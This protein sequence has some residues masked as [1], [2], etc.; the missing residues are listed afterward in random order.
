[1]RRLDAIDRSLAMSASGE[2][3]HEGWSFRRWRDRITAHPAAG[4]VVGG[5]APLTEPGDV[6]VVWRDE[7]SLWIEEWGGWLIFDLDTNSGRSCGV[8]PDWL[9]GQCLLVTAQRSAAR[10]KIA[11]H[12]RSRSL[13]GLY[14]DASIPP[15][16]RPTLPRVFARDQLFYA[17]GLGMNCS[18]SQKVP[19]GLELNW[20]PGKS[21]F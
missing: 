10:L 13:K 15:W 3:L 1:M 14:Q 18:V 16:V 4:D 7:P 17:A 5:I 6:T 21:V 9:R 2:A 19:G 12:A 11:T 20:R 8:D